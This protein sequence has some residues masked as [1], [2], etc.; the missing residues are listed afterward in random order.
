MKQDWNIYEFHGKKSSLF[1]HGLS[2]WNK[3][4]FRIAILHW[5]SCFFRT[6]RVS[7]DMWSTFI[8]QTWQIKTSR[9]SII[10]LC[11]GECIWS[12]NLR[13]FKNLSAVLCQSWKWLP[14]SLALFQLIR[15]VVATYWNKNSLLTGICHSFL[16]FF[17]LLRWKRESAGFFKTYFYFILFFGMWDGGMFYKIVV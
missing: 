4:Q 10:H 7:H 6:N 9:F 13:V 3:S 16:D 5:N 8:L 11:S 14:I 12:N 1:S 2:E 15:A 17:P